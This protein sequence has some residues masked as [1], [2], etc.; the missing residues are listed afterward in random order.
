MS[1]M[2]LLL[3]LELLRSALIFCSS[4]SPFHKI[5]LTRVGVL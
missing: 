5:S 1:D 2:L 3:L 4:A